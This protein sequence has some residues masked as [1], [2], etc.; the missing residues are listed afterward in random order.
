MRGATTASF[1]FGARRSHADGEP[2]PVDGIGTAFT[3]AIAIASRVPMKPGSSIHASS[4][5]IEGQACKQREALAHAARDHD[6]SAS[7]TKPRAMPR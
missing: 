4:P 7:Q 3:S 2:L 6:D 1:A 5:R